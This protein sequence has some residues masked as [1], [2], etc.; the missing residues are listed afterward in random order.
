M[1]PDDKN[2]FV[3]PDYKLNDAKPQK[4]AAKNSHPIS[5]N[6]EP[7]AKQ[8]SDILP[9]PF[10]RYPRKITFMRN[11]SLTEVSTSDETTG[12]GNL[13]PHDPAKDE[14]TVFISNLEYTVTE[15][16]VKNILKEVGT[17]QEFRLVRDFKGRSKGYGYMVFSTKVSNKNLFCLV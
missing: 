15:E 8:Q 17:I 12:T 14:R 1:K 3:K 9:L 4:A 6:K 10:S 16:D 2:V 13:V 11:I 7:S 5:P